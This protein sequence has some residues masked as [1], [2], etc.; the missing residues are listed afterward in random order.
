MKIWKDLR[1]PNIVKF[2][3]FCVEDDSYK[4]NA[5]LVS[6]WCGN[7]NVVEYLRRD[8]EAD[9]SMLVGHC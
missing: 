5:G 1:H 3:G 9:R 6:E 2:I 4:L 8:P 7:G